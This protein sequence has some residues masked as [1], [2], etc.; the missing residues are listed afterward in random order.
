MGDYGSH[1]KYPKDR[2]KLVRHNAK[3]WAVK[4]NS[5]HIRAFSTKRRAIRWLEEEAVKEM[6]TREFFSLPTHRRSD[7]ITLIKESYQC[8]TH[9]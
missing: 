2:F 9:T 8:L 5:D 4:Y 7:G 3:S 1:R 6:F